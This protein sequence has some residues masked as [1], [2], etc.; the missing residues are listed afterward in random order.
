MERRPTIVFQLR[1]YQVKKAQDELL[2]LDQ[3]KRC[4]DGSGT[5]T[6]KT[7]SSAWVAAQLGYP[8]LVVCP[9]SVITTWERVLQDAGVKDALVSNVEQYKTGRKGVWD[10]ER[11]VFDKNW[12]VIWDEIHRGTTGPYSQTTGMVA[13]LKAWPTLPR[14]F[15]SATV[16]DTPTQMRALGYL[17]DLHGYQDPLFW[18]WCLDL[19]CVRVKKPNGQGG[20]V[21]VVEMPKNKIKAQ[22]V[23]TRLRAKTAKFTVRLDQSQVPGFPSNLVT[24]KLFDFDKAVTEAA[25]K[26]YE[27]LARAHFTT[28]DNVKAQITMARYQTEIMKVP[29]LAD[30]VRDIVAEGRSVVVFM[31]FHES[32]DLLAAALGPD[33]V[34]QVRGDDDRPR[35]GPLGEGNRVANVA[36][37]QANDITIALCQSQCGGESIGLHDIH[38]TRPRMS[39]ICPDWDAKRTKQC[40]G[41]IHRDG[42]TPATQMFVLAA[43]TVEEGVYRAIVR[44]SANIDT[45]NDADMIG[46]EMTKGAAE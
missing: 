44:K 13:K 29:I 30:L 23:M 32:M 34:I 6:G 9:K 41:R 27:P 3:W 18:Q 11:W 12:T 10:G 8:T 2:I 31:N 25:R 26:I 35:F 45:L 21:S 17:L 40:L 1:E 20:F 14:L 19:G 43:N 28:S 46:I 39:L 24:A 22:E 15:L 4:V 42:G 38:G 7:Y 33:K 36:R 5:G 16:A 37:F